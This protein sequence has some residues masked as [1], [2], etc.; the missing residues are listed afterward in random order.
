MIFEMVFFSLIC[1]I[2]IFFGSIY[3]VYFIFVIIVRIRIE[4]KRSI[5]DKRL[6]V[7]GGV[8]FFN[9]VVKSIIEE[10][11]FKRNFL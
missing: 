8:E 1:L 7:L 10:I 9:L 5:F 2:Y 6:I 4:S 11:K 3:I